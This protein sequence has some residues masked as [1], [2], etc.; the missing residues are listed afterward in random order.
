MKNQ[1][2]LIALGAAMLASCAD[3]FDQSF[4]VERPANLAEYLYLNDYSA[5]KDYIDQSKYPNFKLG[6]GVDAADYA[7]QGAPYVVANVNFNEVVAGNAMKMGS[8]LDYDAKSGLSMNFG[9]VESFVK[10]ATDAGM[11][12]YGHTLGWHEQQPLKWL[13]ALIEDKPVPVD[14]NAPKAMAYV[15]QLTNGNCEGNEAVNFV[16]REK[17]QA[18][19]N[20][21]TDGVGVGGSRGVMV[22]SVEDQGDDWNTQFF[23]YTPDHIWATGDKY[24]FSMKARADKAATVSLQAHNAPGGYIHWSM[25]AGSYE[26]TTDWKEFTYEGEISADQGAQELHSIAFNLNVMK[27]DNTYYFDD[28]SWQAWSEVEGT[29]T[30]WQSVIDNGSM[31]GDDAKNFA[32]KE[33]AGAIVY[34][35]TDGVG[36]DGSRG[37]KVASKG[38]QAD[39][40]ESQ[41]WIVSN[42]VLNE[43]DKV[44]VKFDYRAEGGCAGTGVDT[45][46]HFGPGEYQHWACAGT[47]QFTSDWQTYDNLFTVDA[48][49]AGANGMKS[50]AFNM[51]PN[52]ADGIYYVDNVTLEVE[53][54]ITASAPV[55]FMADLIANGDMEGDNAANFASKENSGS[56]VYTIYDGVGKDG[57]RGVKID[58]KGGQADAW[59]SQFW[60][61]S[62]EV[63]YDGDKVHVEFDYR[64]DGGCVGTNVD[65]QA[66]FGPGEY[67]HY[68]CAGTVAFGAD[69]QH[70]AK[71]FTVD[72]SM[73]GA[74]GMKS[75]AFNM[76][77]NA[78]DGTY[79]IDNVV[80]QTEKE[81]TSGGIPL[82]PEEKADTL[83]YAL[84]LWVSNMM[85]ACKDDDGNML[86]KA[87]D[88]VNEA[89][90]GG[91]PDSEGAYALQH[92]TPESENAFYWQDYLGD[93]EYVRTLVRLARQYGG[94]DLKLFANDYNLESDWDQN[95]K[96]KS[97]IK[98]IERWEADGVT[99]IDGIGSQMHIWCYEDKA[100][101]ESK[102]NA[103]T[104]MLKLMAATGRLVR[105]S[106]LDMG[107]T[108]AKAGEKEDEHSVA[109]ANMTEEQHHAMADLYK[110][111]IQ[112]YLTI[113]P[114]AQQ[115]GICQW[116]A[117]DSPADS[118]WRPNQPTGLWDKNY[119]RKHT[120]A[121]FADGLSGK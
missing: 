73:A 89:I 80:L 27:G 98:W 58:S 4:E 13:N 109:T 111:V 79:Y 41:F 102:K 91:N 86:V 14:P 120:Y 55:T 104:E 65:T 39:A 44:H 17:G 35:I 29:V 68:A 66:H 64:A 60:I 49:M 19:A 77:P 92:A 70:Y 78:T 2:I 10:T 87:W 118:G 110:W 81:S 88:V 53:K 21:I 38:G 76:S 28:M 99:K 63:L 25:L 115:W 96:L 57:S 82:T 20:R 62:N 43:G 84:D 69:W 22:H 7:K 97:L 33:N 100:L 121:G 32:S 56:I 6:V 12:V 51:S 67:Q 103:I 101:Q 30:V 15:E 3:E 23:I 116:D 107:Y 42:E 46:A 54:E 48:S 108:T 105:I 40:W 36:K 5:L 45:Q 114:V 34:T 50:I 59:E 94:N 83:T 31:E 16:V 112:Q 117:T 18:D 52:T 26:L 119:N 71:D 47:V 8:C 74:N 90:S 37:V 93:L 24:K 72:A 75:I 95:G 106:E 113:V 11:N 85:K 9:T 61:V 1:I